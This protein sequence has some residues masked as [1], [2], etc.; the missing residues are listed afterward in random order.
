MVLELEDKERFT[1]EL[2]LIQSL[3]NPAYLSCIRDKISRMIKIS[4]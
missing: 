1:V 3:A 4:L 2:E